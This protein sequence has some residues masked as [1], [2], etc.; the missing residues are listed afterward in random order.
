VLRSRCHCSDKLLPA[1]FGLSNSTLHIGISKFLLQ[2]LVIF[3]VCKADRCLLQGEAK[4]RVLRLPLR[5][6]LR[7]TGDME[8]IILLRDVTCAVT[9]EFLT[10]HLWFICGLWSVDLDEGDRFEFNA[11]VTQ[12]IKGY[13]GS[14]N[15]EEPP[16]PQFDWRLERPTKINLLCHREDR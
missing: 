16:E 11:R 8:Q 12:Y 5:F 15:W 6:L 13:R 3:R 9:G 2:T 14:A 4:R 1:P 10:D 7:Y